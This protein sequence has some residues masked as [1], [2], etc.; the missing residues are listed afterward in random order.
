MFASVFREAAARAL[1]LPRRRPGQRTPLWQQRQRSADLLA[2]ASKFPDFPILLEATRECLRDVFDV[3]ALREVMADLRSRRTRLVAVD[4]EHASPFAQ[5]LLFR[6][7]GVYMYEGDAPLAERRAAALTLDRDLLRELLGSEELRELLDPRALDEVEL[8]LQRLGD[9]RGARSADHLHDLLRTLGDLT[10]DEIGARVEDADARALQEQLLADGRAIRIRIAGDE[11]LAAIEDAAR[12]RDALGVSLPIGLPGAFTGETER[13]LEGLVRRYARTHGPFV[14]SEVGARLGASVERVQEALTSLEA[15]DAVVLGEFRPGGS[16]REW[17]DPDVLRRLRRRSLALLRREVE[18]VDA[19][20]LGRFLPAW[21]GADRPRGDLDALADAIARL[22]GTSV[23]A[24]ILE[25]DVL[26]VPGPRVPA[27][28]PRRPRGGRRRGLG[29]RRTSRWRRRK[30]D[31]RLPLGG[32]GAAPR[33]VHRPPG[34]RAARRHPLSPR[35]S[36]RIV[37]DG[38]R[39]RRRHRRRAL[40]PRRPLG[41]RLVRRGHE[42]HA[43]A[44]ACVRPWGLREDPDQGARSSAAG[45]ARCGARVPRPA[46]AGGRSSRDSGSRRRPPPSAPMPLARQ[47]L[48]RHGVVTREAVLAEGVPGGFVGIY[49]VFKAMEEAGHVRR[50]YFVAGLG[51]AQFA[52]PGA[53]DRLRSFRPTGQETATAREDDR[54]DDRDETLGGTLV[55]AAADP[56]QPY[57]AAIPWPASEGRPARQAGA[58]VVLADGAP[59]AYLERGGRSLLTFGADPAAWVDALASLVKDGR[60]KRIQ[61]GRIDGEDASAHPTATAAPHGGVRRR[62]PRA[63]APRMTPT[64]RPDDAF[65]ARG[66]RWAVA[67]PHPLAAEAAAAAFAAGGNAVDAALHA[68]VTLAVVSPHMCGVGGDLFALVQNPDG[69][70]VAIDSSGR[71]PAAADADGLRAAHGTAMPDT[72]PGDD[73]GAGRD[74][75]LGGRPPP[76]SGPAVG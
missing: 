32:A 64:A 52:H 65:S 71:A 41:P 66:E 31:A 36:R 55:L 13:P 48:D 35:G 4:T 42:R 15:N 21:Q 9:G 70:L 7:V 68:A 46:P 39:H 67:T 34:G 51:A 11:R 22:Q 25:T 45:R 18:P 53:V 61:L 16:G 17:C 50:G 54:P 62:L 24:S 60:L 72:G 57:G 26:S 30:G 10:D 75:R 23:P 59:A 47:L 73:H 3:P 58:Y 29:R 2:E 63:H 44:A 56:A 37:L 33:T 14:A 6:W 40:P 20:A 76:G 38:A 27:R 28:R 5:S 1:L 19:A 8:E 74:P 49:P 69:K 12:L 43:G